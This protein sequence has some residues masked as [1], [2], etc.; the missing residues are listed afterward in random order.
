M[1]QAFWTPALPLLARN[2]AR[3]RELVRE[4]R[5]GAINE[6]RMN[7]GLMLERNKLSNVA[8]GCMSVGYT[9]TLL[10]ALGIAFGLQANASTANNTHAA[11]V[12]VGV[13]TAV[14]VLCA[15]PWFFLEQPRSQRP[16]PTGQ[17][18]LSVGIRTYWVI[19]KVSVGPLRQTWL[20]LLGYFLVSD[21]WAT[22]S[23][24]RFRTITPGF[25]YMELQSRHLMGV[26]FFVLGW[27]RFPCRSYSLPLF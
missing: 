1:C 20:Y 2:S 5:F 8:F 9:L 25:Q 16:L 22:T 18:Y 17:T 19:L 23:K 4:Y 27:L 12:I 15:A 7:L 13:A 14:W 10:I 3:S 6:A 24:Q 11:V 26:A 21:G